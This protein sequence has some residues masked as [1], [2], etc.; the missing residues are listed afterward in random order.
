AEDYDDLYGIVS[1]ARC[2]LKL[3]KYTE[4]TELLNR[5][6]ILDSVS[7]YWRLRSIAYCKRANFK[8]SNGCINEALRLDPTNTLAGKQKKLLGRLVEESIT[9][10][11]MH[12]YKSGKVK[13]NSEMDNLKNSRSNENPVY[14]ILSIDGG[15]IRAVL[16]ALWLSEIEY[17]AHKPISHLFNMIAGTSTGGIIAAGLSALF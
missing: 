11:R 3:S 2:S 7:E 10:Y 14:N 6:H 5:S 13:I 17:R 12:L 15:G 9:K 1:T 16:P 8:E 4:V